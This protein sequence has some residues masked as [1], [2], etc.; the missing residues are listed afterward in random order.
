MA[1][2]KRASPRPGREGN[3]PTPEEI[4]DAMAKELLDQENAKRVREMRKRHR[5]E[6]EAKGGNLGHLDELYRRRD[7]TA[8][9]IQ[10]FFTG[11]FKTFGAYFDEFA[12]MDFFTRKTTKTEKASFE[13]AGMM[14]G[15]KGEIG[16]P[17][18]NLVGDEIQ[19]WLTGHAKG[20]SAR[21]RNATSTI[22]EISKAFAIADAGGVV[23]GTGKT[24]KA[25]EPEKAKTAAQ[26][27][28]AAVA[29]QAAADFK[30]D[31]PE[32]TPALE[33]IAGVG[34]LDDPSPQLGDDFEAPAEEIAQQAGRPG[35]ATDVDDPLTVDGVKYP[36]KTRA[37]QAR[38]LS[39]SQK[40]EAARKEAGL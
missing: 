2:P 39:Q 18:P 15:L 20:S 6:F 26:K 28:A 9:E 40:A 1:K 23:D 10:S 27:K 21:Q 3:G 19:D 30:E 12:Q 17:P 11:M 24:V 35:G 16:T 13:H 22:D 37:N 36:N 31:N 29:E 8:E 25:V 4:M 32:V 14:A 7:D 34:A 38:T 33:K 5:A